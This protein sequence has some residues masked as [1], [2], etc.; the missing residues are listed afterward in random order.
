LQSRSAHEA[1]EIEFAPAKKYS[2]S[3]RLS[4]AIKRGETTQQERRESTF[5][6]RHKIISIRPLVLCEVSV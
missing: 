5:A 3:P 2:Y 4:M 6:S 1:V